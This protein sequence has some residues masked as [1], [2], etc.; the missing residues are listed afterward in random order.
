MCL[1]S[2]EGPEFIRIFRLTETLLYF[3]TFL[4]K[5]REKWTEQDVS[6]FESEFILPSEQYP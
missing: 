4:R 6:C 2:M 5:Y 1:H 3:I